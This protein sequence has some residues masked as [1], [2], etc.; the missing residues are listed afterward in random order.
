LGALAWHVESVALKHGYQVVLCNSERDRARERSYIT[1][2]WQDGIRDVILG[3]SLPSLDHV[4]DL[5]AHG[6]NVIAFDHRAQ[7]G[8]PSSVM[9]ITV[10]NY[11]GA[12]V[13]TE[14]LLA[15]GH[16]RIAFLSGP[17]RTISR[18]ERVSGYR[19]ALAAAG[20][21]PD[22]GLIWSGGSTRGWGDAKGA[23]LGRLGAR[24]LLGG[25]TRPTAI[26]AINDLYALGACAGAR[27]EGL[28]VPGH[29]SVVGFDDIILAGLV[30][31]PLTTVRQPLREMALVAVQRVLVGPQPGGNGARTLVVEP[32][33]IVRSSTGAPP[34]GDVPQERHE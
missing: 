21:Q 34:T 32:R 29:V 28:A 4:A 24:R 8:D 10:D 23:E 16:R 33:L 25:R 20:V 6:L 3:S 11:R 30:D 9:S 26:F 14:H 13:A 2:L 18:I 19:D 22:R 12:R 17:L 27:D 31:P 5:V 15:L 7:Q 1:E